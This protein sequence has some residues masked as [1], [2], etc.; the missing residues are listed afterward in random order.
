MYRYAIEHI[1]QTK[2]KYTVRNVLKFSSY[3]CE[4]KSYVIHCT[5]EKN[6]L[7]FPEFI[8]KLRNFSYMLHSENRFFDSKKLFSQCKAINKA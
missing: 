7:E 2:V 4:V 1:L 6:Y 3:K 8:S 5:F